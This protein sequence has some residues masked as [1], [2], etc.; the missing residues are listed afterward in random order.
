[1]ALEEAFQTT[2]DEAA[3]ASAKTVGE[4]DGAR[5]RPRAPDAGGPDIFRRPDARR[6][7]TRAR[8]RPGTDRRSRPG[9][10]RFLRGSSAASACRRGSCRSRASSCD[11]KVDGLEHLE[12]LEGPVIFAANHQSHM[13]TPA[14]LIALP[15]RWRY[16]VA[17]AMAK[18]FFKAHFYPGRVRPR[19]RG[20]PT[21]STTTCRRS[22]LQR[23]SRC[24]SARP[25]RGRR[26]GTSASSS[27]TATR[28]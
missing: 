12:E 8:R 27:A 9:T 11:P 13:D 28:S 22:V 5:R 16:R 7:G 17:P 10:D 19:R 18:E 23:V 14:I 25:A 20:S 3:F 4:I 24:R 26:C 6:P 2:L 21:A 1:M 15:P